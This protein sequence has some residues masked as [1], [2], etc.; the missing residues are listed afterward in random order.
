MSDFTL[1]PDLSPKAR[2]YFLQYKDIADKFI[3]RMNRRPFGWETIENQQQM[4][5]ELTK[6]TESF[7]PGTVGT[8]FAS[9][10]DP[11]EIHQY[12]GFVIAIH[13]IPRLNGK[14]STLSGIRKA[15]A[16]IPQ[17]PFPMSEQEFPTHEAAAKAALEECKRKI[18]LINNEPRGYDDL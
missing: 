2:E 1:P 10:R 3:A 4:V 11:L 15:D 17:E 18:D 12:K 6:L 7:P 5:E 14:Y 9:G 16:P 13:T 8:A